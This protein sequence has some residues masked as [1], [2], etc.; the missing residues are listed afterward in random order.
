VSPAERE[1]RDAFEGALGWK[2]SSPVCGAYSYVFIQSPD[3]SVTWLGA[4]TGTGD[5]DH[6]WG[7]ALAT[8]LD[9]HGVWRENGAIVAAPPSAPDAMALALAVAARFGS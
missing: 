2:V 1:L 6:M 3:G 8:I 4:A 5:F 7:T 9:G